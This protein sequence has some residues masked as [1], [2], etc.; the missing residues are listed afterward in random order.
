MLTERLHADSPEDVARA[1]DLLRQGRLVAFPTETVYGL[2]ANALSAEAV[3]GIFHAK[4]RPSWDPLIVHV[5]GLEMVGQVALL[6]GRSLELA[7][8]YWPGPLTLLLPRST[9]VPD[10]VTAGRPLVGVR[11]PGLAIARRLIELA[12][13]P[14]AAPSANRFGH[15]SPTTAQHVLDDLDGR[16]DAVLDGGATEVGVESTVAEVVEHGDIV[17]YRA[18]G[19]DLHGSDSTAWVRLSE[20]AARSDA[21]PESLP[22]PGLGMRHYAPRARLV[23]VGGFGQ[24]ALSRLRSPLELGLV[25]PIDEAMGTGRVGVM[26]PDGWNRGAA[27]AVF[28]WGP[29][30]NAEVLARRVFAGLRAL[31]DESVQVIVCPVPEMDGLG[32]A[33]RDRLGKA[34]RVK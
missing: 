10:A 33:I 19:V 9:R 8:R 3:T 20:A 12:G 28:A 13:A 25:A 6:G 7:R 22:S 11:M 21:A 31:D 1:A 24:A 32:E 5:S 16:I 27:E 18:G 14:V 4:G 15:T 17:V 34:A 30:E 2:G 23:L 29:W 26:L